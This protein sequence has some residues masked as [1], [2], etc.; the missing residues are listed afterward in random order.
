MAGI[1][2]NKHDESKTKQKFRQIYKASNGVG[3][4]VLEIA[5]YDETEMVIW[6]WSHNDLSRLNKKT[7]GMLNRLN[8][9][10]PQY[11]DA[12]NRWHKIWEVI[13]SFEDED[14]ANV[15]GNLQLPVYVDTVAR[16]A[17]VISEGVLAVLGE[18]KMSMARLKSYDQMTLPNGGDLWTVWS[19]V[20]ELP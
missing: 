3:F 19:R 8:E 12:N 11:I 2:P 16:K 17:P 10:A 9:I 1:A 20:G 14:W 4:C 7:G 5:Y 15:L 18:V 13:A 6:K